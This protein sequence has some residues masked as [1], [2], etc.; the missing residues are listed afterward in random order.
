MPQDDSDA[1]RHIERMLSAELRD[2]E[3]HVSGI[4]HI[5]THSS[6]F[7]SENHGIFPPLFR[8]KAVEHYR[9]HRLLGAYDRIPVLLQTA[10]RIHRIINMFPLHAVLRAKG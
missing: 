3:A 10:D 1:D 2:L 6:H 5:L 7:I 4:Y 8:D 9:T